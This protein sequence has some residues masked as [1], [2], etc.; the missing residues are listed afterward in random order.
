MG[1]IIFAIILGLI[2]N[3]FCTLKE[4]NVNNAGEGE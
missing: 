1:L 3:H 4:D 2:Y